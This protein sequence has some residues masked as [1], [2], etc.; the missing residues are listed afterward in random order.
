MAADVLDRSPVHINRLIAVR[1]RDLAV[2]LE[3][4]NESRPAN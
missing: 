4:A 3:K 1:L 2:K